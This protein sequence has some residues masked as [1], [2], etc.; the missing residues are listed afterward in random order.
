MRTTAIIPPRRSCG[1]S[2]TVIVVRRYS[3]PPSESAL[4]TFAR[5]PER[6]SW[7]ARSSTANFRRLARGDPGRLP[8]GD[9]DE[10]GDS[11]FAVDCT[12][13]DDSTAQLQ[14]LKR[15]GGGLN[16]R[17][18]NPVRRE[19]HPRHHP[20]GKRER[21]AFLA[22]HQ[23]HVADPALRPA[24]SRRTPG[25]MGQKYSVSA[26]TARSAMLSDRVPLRQP[27]PVV[28]HQLPAPDDQRRDHEHNRDSE[29]DLGQFERRPDSAALRRHFLQSAALSR[30]RTRRT[31]AHRGL[32]DRRGPAFE[33]EAG[34]GLL[35]MLIIRL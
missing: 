5:G 14:R 33:L 16:S 20:I 2:V 32:P 29:P 10:H 6:G 34:S 3:Q 27:V 31:P 11:R 15:G 26:E 24:S 25:S 19:L 35:S 30:N 18:L 28:A 1:G 7:P 4:D 9:L 23:G 17:E 22:A 13:P 8:R 21:F 12:V